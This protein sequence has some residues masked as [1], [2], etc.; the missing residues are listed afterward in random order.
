MKSLLKIPKFSPWAHELRDYFQEQFSDPRALNSSRFV[1]DYWHVPEQYTLLR[2]PAYE[3]FPKKLYMKLHMDLVMWGRRTLGCWDIS[4]PW[5]SCYVEGCEQKIHSDLPHGPWAFVYSLSPR[6]PVFKGGETMLLRE[7]VL[8]YWQ[9]PEGSGDN[10]YRGLIELVKPNY[11]QLTVFDPRIPHG[12][13]RVTGTQDPREGRLVVHGWFSNPKTFI[14]GYLPPARTEKILNQGF[15]AVV[16]AMGSQGL[17]G[18]LSIG[19]QVGTDGK[20]KSAK[21]FTATVRDQ[22]GQEPRTFLNQILRIY[23]DLEF[24]QAR[25][26]TQVTIPLIFG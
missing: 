17:W 6:S 9:N 19:L 5:L 21:F 4:P 18:T 11:N 20:V 12:V 24:P 1:W 26:K 10:E 23:R 14:D 8:N 2:T 22:F 3:Y 25:G 7:H 13:A 16:T 15:D